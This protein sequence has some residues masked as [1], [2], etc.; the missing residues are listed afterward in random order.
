MISVFTPVHPK[1]RPWLDEAARSLDAQTYQD[2]EWVV[3]PNGFDGG[4]D[5]PR[6]GLP[7][8]RVVEFPGRSS[9]I[10]ELKAFAAAQCGGDILVELDADDWL[11][12][13]ALEEIAKAF[14][15][16]MVQV[17]YSNCA[18]VRDGKST[19]P[20]DEIFGWRYRDHANGDIELLSFPPTVHAMRRILWAPNHVRA[21]R[22]DGYIKV[23]GHDPKLAVG[24]DHDLLCRCYLEYGERGFAQ[25][26]K[27]LYYYRVHPENTVKLKNKEIQQQAELNY[28]KYV[29][30]MAM[31]WA[32][33]H[34]LLC[35]DMGGSLNPYPDCEIWDKRQGAQWVVDLNTSDFPSANNRVGFLRAHHVL[36]HLK[37][38]IRIMNEAYRVLAPG[39]FFCIEVPSTDGRG[40]FAD[41][42]HKS[43]WNVDSFAYYT[44]LRKARFIQP[45]FEGRFQVSRVQ[46]YTWP[47]GTAV[48]AA[49]LI[50]LKPPYDQRPPGQVLI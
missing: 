19:R 40:A 17:A 47:D 44:D 25:I 27:L 7:R 30:A 31:R 32:R 38:P 5:V 35:V 9:R 2:F 48:V 23:G 43:F 46:P 36:E 14:A 6:S 15:D 1:S 37:D 41:P 29:E 33:D 26:D 4:Y 8:G 12:P 20:Y 39:G 22:R 10:G 18:E 11:A 49:E 28:V 34:K 24:D 42:T 3:V 45:E 21:W 13:T 50:C 16:P